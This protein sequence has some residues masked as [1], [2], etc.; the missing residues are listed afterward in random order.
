MRATALQ[1]HRGRAQEVYEQQ[2]QFNQDVSLAH[3]FERSVQNFSTPMKPI[4]GFTKA[5]GDVENVMEPAQHTL[6]LRVE[7][8]EDFWLAF[9]N[10][11]HG[12][13]NE[14]EAVNSSLDFDSHI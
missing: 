13:I 9:D 11:D 6:K 2:N 4:S 7:T 3:T 14:D 1:S 8:Q 5:G 10:E 12:M